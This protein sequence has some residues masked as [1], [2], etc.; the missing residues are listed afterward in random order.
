ML[1]RS[2]Y[3]IVS[4]LTWPHP[5]TH[6]STH[7]WVGV[8]L[9]IINLQTELNYLDSVNN[10]QIFS[11][12]TWPH[13]ST[14]PP[15]YT[16]TH[17][18]GSLHRFQIFKQNWNISISSSAIEFWM[19][20]GVP[21]GGWGVGGW[22]EGWWEGTPHPCAHTCMHARVYDIIGNSQGFPQWGRPFAWNYHLYHVC[23]CVHAC[24]HVGYTHQPPPTT[25]HPSPHPRAAGSP[26]HQNSISLELIKI[27][28]FCLK[29]LYL[30]TFLNSYR[31]YL[32][33]QEPP[34]PPAPPLR[35]EETQIGRITI[36][37]ERIKIIQFCLKIWDP[38]TLLHTYKRL[39]CRWG[40]SYHK[41]HFYVFDPKK[42]S[43]DPPI[44]NFLFLHWIPLDHIEIEFWEDF[45][46]PNPFTTLSNSSW[47][48]DQSAKLN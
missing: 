47:N 36:T 28:R 27:I 15:N 2:T 3:S 17:G 39:M 25:I 38:W 7:P 41:W 8:S 18:W 23:V 33:T 20:L 1:I 14:H 22:G 5:L 43:C 34:H 6:P 13:P 37:L 32:I 45:W 35:A 26:K 46:P 24:A 44:K 16:P 30:W 11:D 21:P 42:C 48:E 40:V 4:H 10:F 9:Q 12:L 19:I 29:I 31:L